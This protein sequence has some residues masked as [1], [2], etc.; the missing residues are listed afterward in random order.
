MLT[1]SFFRNDAVKQI[2]MELKNPYKPLKFTVCRDFVY[3]SNSTVPGGFEV[4]SYSTLLTPLTSFMMR[5][6]TFI[7]IS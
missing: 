7:R 5:F 6:I 1:A 4:R 3:Y 2:V